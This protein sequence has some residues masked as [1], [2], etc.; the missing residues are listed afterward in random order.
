MTAPGAIRLPAAVAGDLKSTA[1][2]AWPHEAC[3]LLIG[4]RA[5]DAFEVRRA[6]AAANRA[7]DPATAFEID[8]Q[9]WLDTRAALERAGGDDAII[10][11]WHSHPNGNPAP[12]PR[13]LEAA[14]EPGF[15][16]LIVPVQ[17]GR[18][19]QPT[20]HLFEAGPGDE[21]VRSARRFHLLPI[22]PA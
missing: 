11:C 22:R 2:A 17:D 3:G 8:P 10:G 1:E 12:S 13:D 15:L 16:W 20:A 18:A 6:I 7:A 4:R 21:P 5:S 9:L 19:A 14:W